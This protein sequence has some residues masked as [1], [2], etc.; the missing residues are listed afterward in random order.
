MIIYVPEVIHKYGIWKCY[1]MVCYWVSLPNSVLTDT[2]LASNVTMTVFTSQKP[3][4][5]R[6]QGILPTPLVRDGF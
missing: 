1:I 6:S 4:N 5:P 3:V 2:A